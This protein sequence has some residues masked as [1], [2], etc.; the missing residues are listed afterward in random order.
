MLQ[1][2][3]SK[4]E[5]DMLISEALIASDPGSGTG[6]ASVVPVF[7]SERLAM[8]TP[9]HFALTDPAEIARLVDANPLA[10]LVAMTPAG[11]VANHIPL[12]REGEG[13]VG[14]VAL[15]NDLHRDLPEGAPV[16]AIF[17]AGDAYV[18]PNWYPTKAATHRAVPTWN[19]RVVHV[20]AT[21]HWSHADRDKRR[22]V[23]LLTTQ[24]ERAVNGA[25]GWRM[26]DAPADYMAGMLEKIVAF[27]LAVTKTEAKVK[28]NQNRVPEDIAGVADAYEKGGQVALA[29]AM[30]PPRDG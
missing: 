7:V 20:H 24:H 2:T 14:H 13:F 29:Q 19:Y 25:A 6:A 23:S 22:A 21:I 5:T 4:R 26:G 8:Y 30:R 18:S 17:Q 3:D 9:A 11:L 27:R 16:L 10:A 15:A 28:L 1:G 12:L